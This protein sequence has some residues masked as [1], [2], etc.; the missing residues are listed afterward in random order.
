MY[1]LKKNKRAKVMRSD[2]VRMHSGT[3][4][5]RYISVS[6]VR[7]S[8]AVHLCLWCTFKALCSK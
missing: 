1:F 4:H 2:R 5:P 3:K 7:Y 6:L 8:Y